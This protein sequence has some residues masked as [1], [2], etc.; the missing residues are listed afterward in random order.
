MRSPPVDLGLHDRVVLITGASRGLGRA[1]AL[2]FAAEGARL[3]LCARGEADL[4]AVASEVT[5]CGVEA[6]SLPVDVTAPDAG[7][8]IVARI[9][10]RWGR[11]D[12]LV[13][14]AG[15]G[16]RRAF[17]ALDDEA[18][19]ASVE[20]N[21]LASLALIR[22]AIPTMRAQGGGA[23]VNVAAAS[24]KRPRLGQSVSNTTK[25]ALINLTESLAVELAPDGIRV[26]AGCP[27]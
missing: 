15:G 20:L 19:Q 8:R 17:V 1:C 13:N 9:V 26:N 24:G 4:K 14:N 3:A 10:E 22:A 21:P 25:A 5:A 18:W 23:I 7:K 11:L 2:A 16:E 6:E 12:V 27:G